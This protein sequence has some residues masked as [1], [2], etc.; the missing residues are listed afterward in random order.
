VR[1]GPISG[2]R[3]EETEASG[4]GGKMRRTERSQRI[5]ARILEVGMLIALPILCHCLIPIKIVVARPYSYLGVGVM[6]LGLALMTWAAIL[7]RNAGTGFQLRGGESV[8]VTLGPFRFSRN[9]MYLGMLIWLMGLAVLLGSLTAFLFPLL[10]FLLADR[11]LIPLEERDMERTAGERFTE[12][13][14][15]VRRWL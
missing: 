3:R 12:Y 8:L 15:R 11:L 7:F 13:E 14:R 4:T 9:P 1:Q 10:F 6:L 2:R 5:G